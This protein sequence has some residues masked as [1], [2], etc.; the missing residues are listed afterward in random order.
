MTEFRLQVLD[1]AQKE[2]MGMIDESF[3]IMAKSSF[4]QGS[5][6]FLQKQQVELFEIHHFGDDLLI[7]EAK[8]ISRK[9]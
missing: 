1:E 2:I 4:L 8:N 6:C 7:A 9:R 3:G 5:H